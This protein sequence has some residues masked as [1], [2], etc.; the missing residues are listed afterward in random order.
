M[1]IGDYVKIIKEP[2]FHFYAVLLDSSYGD[3]FEIQCCEKKY[4]KWVLKK[5]D[6]DSREPAEM[7]K[8]DAEIDG[9][10]HYI[11]SQ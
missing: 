9:R 1:K 3:E 4:R 5:N 8:V 6:F 10:G 2:Y 7:I 11:F